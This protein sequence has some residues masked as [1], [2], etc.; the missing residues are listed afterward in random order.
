MKYATAWSVAASTSSIAAASDCPDGRRHG[1]DDRISVAARADGAADDDLDIGV[2]GTQREEQ[3]DGTAIRGVELFGRVAESGSPI[4]ICSPGCRFNDY[5]VP[6]AACEIDD[7]L[8]VVGERLASGVGLEERKG[9]EVG[10]ID[11]M[12]EEQ[13]GFQAGFTEE[14]D[15]SELW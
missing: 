4:E 2:V 10:Q 13:I 7:R 9:R 12:V 3:G 11:A 14:N 8:V 5:A 1:I 6:V 15:A